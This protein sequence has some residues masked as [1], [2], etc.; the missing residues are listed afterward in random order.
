M[1]KLPDIIANKILFY[2]CN[3]TKDI[4]DIITILTFNN[5]L[6][7]YIADKITFYMCKPLNKIYDWNSNL[8]RK[9][10]CYFVEY[11]KM[12]TWSSPVSYHKS[13]IISKHYLIIITQTINY[14]RI[15]I[16]RGSN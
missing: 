4:K 15:R 3:P 11:A 2:L 6:D 7:I 12:N 1:S 13:P 5:N 16:L 10:T 9:K 14:Q 8:Q